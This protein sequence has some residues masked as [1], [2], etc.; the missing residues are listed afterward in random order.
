[1][2]KMVSII[3][4]VNDILTLKQSLLNI[5]K[6]SY[7]KWECFI[8]INTNKKNIYDIT[9]ISPS[10]K[11]S[12]FNKACFKSYNDILI[13]FKEYIKDF[14]IIL[15]S[16]D[17]C[18]VKKL[19]MQV[20]FMDKN[21][22]CN[23]CSC[24]SKCHKNEQLMYTPFSLHNNF[25]SGNDIDKAILA[26]YFPLC[27]YTFLMRKTFLIEILKVLELPENTILNEIDLVLFMLKYAQ[28]E[29]IN[30]ILYYHI[31]SP[32]LLYKCNL[33]KYQNM[34]RNKLEE[35]N[36]SQFIL[37]RSYFDKMLQDNM[38]KVTINKTIYN[39]LIII[40]ELN[41]GGTETYILN[42]VKSLSM[43]GFHFIIATSGGIMA[44]LFKL[45][46]IKIVPFSIE[47][48][49]MTN[50]ISDHTYN[51]L[52]KIIK[53]NNINLLHCHLPKEMELCKNFYDLYEFPY[54]ITLHGT[55][56]SNL[57]IEYSCPNASLVIAVS[58]KIAETYSK[59][60]TKTSPNNVQVIYNSI[61]SEYI[62]TKTFSL[63][64][65]LNIPKRS[66]I[67][68]YC[69]RLSWSKGT[70]AETFL[71]SFEELLYKY[72]DIYAVILGEGTKRLRIEQ[73][74]NDI[75][76]KLKIKRVFNLGAA[77]NVK[78]YFKDSVFVVGTGRVALEALS[79]SKA[80]LALG[81]KGYLGI[82]NEENA[83]IMIDQYFG[84]H[85]CDNPKLLSALT[86]DM[87]M[88][89]SNNNLLN[90]ISIWSR[91]WVIENF[92]EKKLSNKIGKLYIEAIENIKI[93]V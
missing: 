45:N 53:D 42:L 69:S 67:I 44:D 57:A 70:I 48:D 63:S 64:D 36:K 20:N 76:N 74:S 9:K 3:L 93:F 79:C 56:Y 11:I 24:L 6:Q 87:D 92:D 73:L 61:D 90:S 77:Y 75:N 47:Y 25:S 60:L 46:N 28:V 68:V 43:I 49:K 23:I 55:F 14:F 40:D 31:I 50:N 37:Y 35:Y 4:I 91:R 52:L 72:D 7:K 81:V 34:L 85:G 10:L 86:E 89:L 83:K 54:V 88:L 78:D 13:F 26:G 51:K 33:D 1:M 84:D 59:I 12:Y 2:K 65:I 18:D 30:D 22:N 16:Y 66:R 41:L 5:S 71:K 21:S 82:V 38:R 32:N 15:N 19:K 62:N 17:I 80:V 27:L 58:Y 39:I 29:K 8:I